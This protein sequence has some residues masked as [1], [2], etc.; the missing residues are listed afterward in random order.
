MAALSHEQRGAV[1]L[2]REQRGGRGKPVRSE[3][4]R[5]TTVS[6]EEQQWRSPASRE[7]R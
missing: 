2:A 6:M 1:D 3:A 7:K 4:R 5:R